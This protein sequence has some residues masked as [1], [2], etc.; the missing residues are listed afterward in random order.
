V[1]REELVNE[2][3]ASDIIDKLRMETK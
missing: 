1:W 3:H 2:D